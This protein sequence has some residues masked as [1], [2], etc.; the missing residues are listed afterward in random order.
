M[1]QR[2]RKRLLNQGTPQGVSLE[3]A[4]VAVASQR[5]DARAK[6]PYTAAAENLAALRPSADLSGKSAVCLPPPDLGAAVAMERAER[7]IPSQ[8][9]LR[10][11]G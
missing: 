5:F 3:R 10:P 7:A 1:T 4:V 2:I 11:P 8:P 9:S 6:R